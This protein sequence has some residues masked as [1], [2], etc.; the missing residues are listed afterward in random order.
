MGLII[1]SLRKHNVLGGKNAIMKTWDKQVATVKI[2]EA[3]RD[4]INQ[5]ITSE[6]KLKEIILI[7]IAKKNHLIPENY[8]VS[9]IGG[10]VKKNQPKFRNTIKVT[11]ED[12]RQ[13]KCDYPE[14]GLFE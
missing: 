11:G 4:N 2:P 8:L 7:A 1:V 5:I 10:K 3:N 14:Y 12:I 6:E 9:F 13:F